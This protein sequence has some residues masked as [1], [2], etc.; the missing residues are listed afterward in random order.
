MLVGTNIQQLFSK[1]YFFK[2]KASFNPNT[3]N[4][5]PST[6]LLANHWQSINAGRGSTL[7]S[8]TCDQDYWKNIK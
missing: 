4:N 1:I 3:L 6:Y 7:E 2:G 5:Q 8:P